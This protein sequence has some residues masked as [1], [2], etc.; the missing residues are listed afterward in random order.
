MSHGAKQPTNSATM[1]VVTNADPP[2]SRRILLDE[3]LPHGLLVHRM[4]VR[5]IRMGSG[6][7]PGAHVHNGPVFGTVVEGRVLFQVDGTAQRVLAPG[8][9][10]YEPGHAVIRH[11]DALGEDVTFLA[12]FPLA[13]GQHPDITTVD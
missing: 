5:E 4:E 7:A 2:M 9:A 3:T 8:E 1:R 6:Y 12:Y 11:F 10:F 13:Q